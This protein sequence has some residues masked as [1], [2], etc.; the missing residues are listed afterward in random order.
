MSGWDKHQIIQDQIEYYRARASEY[1]EWFYRQGRFDRGTELNQ[2]WFN[3]AAAVKQSLHQLGRVDR[4]LELAC[5]TG[6]WTQEL[7]NIGNQITAIDAS[8][9]MLEINRRKLG[10]LPQITYQQ[11]DI[12]TWEPEQTYDLV[13][14]SFWLSHVPPALLTTFLQAVARA[15]GSGGKL[16]M[17]DSRFEPTSTASN[18]TLVDDGNMIKTRKLNNGKE[19]QIVKIFYQPNEL[20]QQLRAIGID[21]E[22]KVTDH[23][24]IYAIGTKI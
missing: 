4:V 20:Q 22:V 13:F 24:F 19:F 9:E 21:S 11:R 3:E 14:F 7:L 10:V 5:G 18:H 12:F 8:A 23:Y 2:Q 6:I 1:D 15:I 16:F 17:I